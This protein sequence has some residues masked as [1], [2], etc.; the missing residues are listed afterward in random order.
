[1]T[2]QVYV[3]AESEV[4]IASNRT[5]SLQCLLSCALASPNPKTKTSNHIAAFLV[6]SVF[7]DP[8]NCAA[9]CFRATT[10]SPLSRYQPLIV[11]ADSMSL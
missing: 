11:R 2:L 8:C 7:V 5:Q 9:R 4:V 1:M 10:H 3:F 6:S